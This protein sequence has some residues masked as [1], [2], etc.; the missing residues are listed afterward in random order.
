MD[1]TQQPLKPRLIYLSH[2]PSTQAVLWLLEELGID[3]DITLIDRP[4]KARAVGLKDTHVQGHA[5]QLI[6]PDGR[7]ITQMS[8]CMLHLILTYDTKQAFHKTDVEYRVREDY[9]VSL[10]TADLIA[11]L[12]VKHLF[13]V[14]GGIMPFPISPL[15]KTIGYGLDKIYL[16][17]DVNNALH[18][19]EI[20]LQGR[21][22]VMG[23]DAPSRA[24]M[25][26]KIALD[27]AVHPKLI[28]MDKWPRVKAWYD[29]CE[30]RPAWKRSLNKGI[31]YQLDWKARVPKS[32]SWTW[33]AVALIGS[34]VVY[35]VA[36]KWV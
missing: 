5:P 25:A 21:D 24:D 36:T 14:L 8:A 22:W 13:M 4:L 9:L 30:A 33:P 12:G 18:V 11:R 19:V 28:E 34:A 2:S 35:Q 20:E 15:F 29:R 6:L 31:G 7:I 32:S 17:E 3:Y 1:E 23:G 10:A 16:D 27:M 26:L